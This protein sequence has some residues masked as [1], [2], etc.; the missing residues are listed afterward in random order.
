MI[1]KNQDQTAFPYQWDS[2]FNPSVLTEVGLTKLEYAA[3]QIM[4]YANPCYVM[5][6]ATETQ[7]QCSREL[8]RRSVEAARHLF[9]ELEKQAL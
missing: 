8:A 3:I 2:S 5:P 4:A 1:D 7:E 6:N 9:K